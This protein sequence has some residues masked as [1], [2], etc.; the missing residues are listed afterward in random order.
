MDTSAFDE[1]P[2]AGHTEDVHA[3]AVLQCPSE[4]LSLP[5]AAALA[6]VVHILRLAILVLAL[7]A[8]VVL[9]CFTLSWL[10]HLW[11]QTSL[12]TFAAA[13]LRSCIGHEPALEAQ[14]RVP[15]PSEQWLHE[16]EPELLLNAVEHVPNASGSPADRHEPKPLHQQEP[17]SS[18]NPQKPHDTTLNISS[19]ANLPG[20]PAHSQETAVKNEHAVSRKILHVP[21]PVLSDHEKKAA[22]QT[23]FIE[24]MKAGTLTRAPQPSAE[25]PRPRTTGDATISRSN[26]FNV[27]AEQ[28]AE[29]SSFMSTAS[30]KYK[31]KGSTGRSGPRSATPRVSNTR[32]FPAAQ[33]Q[34]PAPTAAPSVST[35]PE[36]VPPHIRK[37]MQA[38]AVRAES[39][40]LQ[41]TSDGKP[42]DVRQTLEKSEGD[43]AAGNGASSVSEEPG[44]TVT[45]EHDETQVEGD[46]KLKAGLSSEIQESAVNGLADTFN[47]DQETAFTEPE[48]EAVFSRKQPSHPERLD[49]YDSTPKLGRPASR[50]MTATALKAFQT[51][52]SRAVD[53]RI[54]NA[55]SIIEGFEAKQTSPRLSTTLFERPIRGVAQEV[56]LPTIAISR[57]SED[58]LFAKDPRSDF[59]EGENT[60]ADAMQEQASIQPGDGVVRHADKVI[61]EQADVKM[62]AENESSGIAHSPQ[63]PPVE[64]SADAASTLEFTSDLID[65]DVGGDTLTDSLYAESI[66]SAPLRPSSE[67]SYAL[68]PSALEA[69]EAEATTHEQVPS[70]TPGWLSVGASDTVESSGI[71]SAAPLRPPGL[72][73]ARPVNLD[74]FDALLSSGELPARSTSAKSAELLEDFSRTSPVPSQ[75]REDTATAAETDVEFNKDDGDQTS[76]S[77]GG[78]VRDI[79][80]DVPPKTATNA[81]IGILNTSKRQAKEQK[82]LARD[83]LKEAWLDREEA[84]TGVLG[85]NWT[86][87]R[88]QQLESTTRSYHKAREALASLMPSGHLNEE[89]SKYFPEFSPW[90]LTAP[91]FRPSGI[92]EIKARREANT[93]TSTFYEKPNNE[94]SS[95]FDKLMENMMSARKLRNDIVAPNSN[96]AAH[97]SKA[98][99]A[100]KLRRANLNYNS[101]RKALAAAF[102]D[103]VLPVELDAQFPGIF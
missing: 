68:G 102:P 96:V 66:S 12:L 73:N 29:A 92:K 52:S 91:K 70:T 84:R 16:P 75:G 88:M 62:A 53:D 85:S 3:S 7:F 46:E 42:M 65:L 2:S 25:V 54:D 74:A 28:L 99:A 77:T 38:K 56:P 61:Q 47:T 15:L 33:P 80:D 82:R 48:H 86:L 87:A 101:K 89:D 45:D 71:G 24:N 64:P 11:L 23:S 35:A 49:F 17:S 6:V 27:T 37:S 44:R 4:H 90:S 57:P 103:G 26:P 100:A 19:T 79:E 67:G 81:S 20:E 21:R 94:S 50:A 30:R 13:L 10:V 41:V 95:D 60:D 59:I 8:C 9:Y 32:R 43:V 69:T 39:E 18:I 51:T 40:D 83:T 1:H 36:L 78:P 58:D 72:E 22:A 14:R 63:Y 34:K 97:T 31:S 98:E 76:L 5:V 55:R 93:S